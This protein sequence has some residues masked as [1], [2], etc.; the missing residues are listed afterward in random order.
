MK[1]D[2]GKK[3]NSFDNFMIQAI[4]FHQSGKLSITPSKMINPGKSELQA[5]ATES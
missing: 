1:Y 3:Y 2:N 4:H 5:I